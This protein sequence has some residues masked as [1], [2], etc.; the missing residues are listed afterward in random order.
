LT[1]KIIETNST[2][3]KHK[4]GKGISLNSELE[5]V[6]LPEELKDFVEDLKNM[7]KIKNIEFGKE[8]KLE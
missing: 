2:I 4:K 6:T 1:E 8:L 3:W 7:H 5:K